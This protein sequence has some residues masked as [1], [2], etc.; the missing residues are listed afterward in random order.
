[1]RL[2]TLDHNGELILVAPS[3]NKIPEYAIL[4]HTWVEGQEVTY[5]DLISGENKEKISYKKIRFCI[6]QA[7]RDGLL[8]AWVDT[9]CI[10]K[11]S[12]AELSEAIRS[13]FDY[14]K[15]AARCYVYLSDVPNPDDLTS[16]IEST[17]T[18]SRWFTRGWTI[19]E[20][21]APKQVE[22]FSH[23]GKSLGSKNS[24]L[25]QIHEITGI[26]IKAL[27]GRPMSEFPIADRMSWAA[28][29]ETT[30][31]EDMAYCLLGIF[32]IH[33][34]VLYGE[35]RESAMTRL[36]R[37]LQILTNPAIYTWA[38]TPLI[39]PLDRQ[40]LFTDS[41]SKLKFN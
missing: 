39:A 21:I 12:D 31:P 35:G 22:F 10:N 3:I 9:C 4:S 26:A 40:N 24:R 23:Q 17:F 8:Y 27:E 34:P 16:T 6:E 5:E 7:A 29:R 32:G 28:K 38:E 41:E 11:S 2:I 19:Q 30:R 33:M 1:M 37:E 18:T 25:Q 14:Y 13:M 20:L 36:Q 15:K